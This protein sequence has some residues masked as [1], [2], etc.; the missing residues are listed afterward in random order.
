M[1]LMHYEGMNL[2]MNCKPVASDFFYL[3]PVNFC[4][5]KFGGLNMF[6]QLNIS[7]P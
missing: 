5:D 4:P 6:F 2:T 3:R 1:L 7:I